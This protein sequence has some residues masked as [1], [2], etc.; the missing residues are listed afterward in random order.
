MRFKSLLVIASLVA[1]AAI[2][3][4]G[5]IVLPPAM[6]TFVT[7]STLTL[8]AMS[9]GLLVSY[10]LLLHSNVKEGDAGSIASVGTKGSLIAAILGSA[11]LAFL[12]AVVGYERAAWAMIVVTI[13]GYIVGSL[14]SAKVPEFVDQA[15]DSTKTSSE[16]LL[17]QTRVKAIIAQVTDLEV[18]RCLGLLEEKLRFAASGEP[19]SAKNFNDDIGESIATLERAVVD[20]ECDSVAIQNAIKRVSSLIDQR[21]AFLISIRSRA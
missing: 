13:A 10:P 9:I 1:F 12:L 6:R 15:A 2:M 20:T 18:R 14:V 4:I 19:G 16:S 8:L 17:W 11:L 21:N 5:Y 7:I 3:G